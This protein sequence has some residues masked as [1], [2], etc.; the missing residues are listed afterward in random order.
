MY[1][2]RV[3]GPESL[4]WSKWGKFGKGYGDPDFNPTMPNIEH[5]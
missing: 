5:L 2:G 1:L 4:C 3:I